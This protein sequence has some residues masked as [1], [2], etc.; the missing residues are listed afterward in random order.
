MIDLS[1]FDKAKKWWKVCKP[2]TIKHTFQATL[3]VTLFQ[4]PTKAAIMKGAGV[5]KHF[6]KIGNGTTAL[7]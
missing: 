1:A 5:G 2:S 3:P 7:V 4:V 6:V